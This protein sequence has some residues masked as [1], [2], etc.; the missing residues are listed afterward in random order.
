MHQINM[1]AILSLPIH[2]IYTNSS[3][4]LDSS[5]SPNC[6]FYIAKIAHDI[7][8]ALNFENQEY[9]SRKDQMVCK[10]VH[11]TVSLCFKID[12]TRTTD[13]FLQLPYCS[14]EFMVNLSISGPILKCTLRANIG[15]IDLTI[16]NINQVQ[17]LVSWRPDSILR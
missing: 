9:W 7:K 4:N 11:T 12:S 2:T 16:K 10:I 15:N 8:K 13:A 6:K 3:K 1:H 17:I 5:L 14:I